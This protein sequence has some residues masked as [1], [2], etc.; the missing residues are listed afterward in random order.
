MKL[1]RLPNRLQAVP[2]TRVPV[3]QTTA[4]ATPRPAGGSWMA[5]RRKVMQRDRYTCAV[6]GTVRLDHE[7]DHI[8]PLEQGGPATDMANLQLLCAWV[9]AD[10]VKRGCH[11]DK[12]AAEARQR[13]GKG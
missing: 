2:H 13:A 9:D 1:N 7:V 6:C 10:G 3:L 11:A 12:T 4:G 5:L 8:I